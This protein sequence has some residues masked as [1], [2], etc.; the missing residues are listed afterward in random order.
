MHDL[1]ELMKKTILAC[2]L[3]GICVTHAAVSMKELYEQIA[4]HVTEDYYVEKF[5][6]LNVPD[7]LREIDVNVN[8]KWLSYTFVGFKGG[9]HLGELFIAASSGDVYEVVGVGPTLGIFSFEGLPALKEDEVIVVT[10][11]DGTGEHH[12]YGIW[13]ELKEQVKVVA[14]FPLHGRSSNALYFEGLDENGGN[15]GFRYEIVGIKAENNALSITWNFKSIFTNI[16]EARQE[17]ML[18]INDLTQINEPFEVTITRDGK[19]FP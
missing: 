13:L 7:F 5:K 8:D 3:S 4:P 14:I 6:N 12:V 15:L 17:D 11:T 2:F 18:R 1:D 10:S 16:D 9:V 19:G